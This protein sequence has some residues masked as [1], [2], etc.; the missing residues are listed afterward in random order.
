MKQILFSILA[1][2]TITLNAQN[3]DAQELIEK[4]KQKFELVKDYT[5]DIQ[6]DLD[7]AF[8]KT[9]KVIGTLYYKQ[10]DKVKIKSEGFALLPKEGFNF[11]PAALLKD[12]YTAIFEREND[13]DGR[14]LAKIKI[15]PTGESQNVILSTVWVDREN[16]VIR[17]I[18]STT[19]KSGTFVIKLHYNEISLKKYPLPEKMEFT[20]DV[21]RLNI[22]KGFS[23]DFDD[24]EQQKKKDNKKRITNG[25]VTVLYNNYRVNT[26]V[27]DEMFM[28]E[29]K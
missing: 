4:V 1:L 9:P 15:V 23:G 14:T 5:V 12:N 7:V 25:S 20:F 24:E 19:K 3:V 16:L 22:P 17:Q 13:V 18:E 6:V 29:K 21:N 2:F 26:G 28:D 27:K 8:L 10:P 11:S